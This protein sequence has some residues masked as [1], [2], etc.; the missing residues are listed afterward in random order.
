[1]ILFPDQWNSGWPTQMT[2]P[3]V[4]SQLASQGESLSATSGADLEKITSILL[5][6][7]GAIDTDNQ[8]V[9]GLKGVS[10]NDGKPATYMGAVS[11][12]FFTHYGV[13]SWNK[14]VSHI[15]LDVWLLIYI[16]LV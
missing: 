16:A 3:S 2:T 11:P 8:Y 9:N 10:S 15:F 4:N 7:V 13:N 12:W 6:A 1:M 5:P 14:N